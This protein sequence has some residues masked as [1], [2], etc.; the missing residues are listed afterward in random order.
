MKSKSERIEE[1]GTRRV[2]SNYQD[3]MDDRDVRLDGYYDAQ[4]L[5]DIAD[6]MEE[7]E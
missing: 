7:A 1:I 3:L 5:R 2:G 4:Q 6:V